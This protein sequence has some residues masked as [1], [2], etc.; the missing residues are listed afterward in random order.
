MAILASSDD[1]LVSLNQ[2]L[3]PVVDGAYGVSLTSSAIPEALRQN[4]IETTLTTTAPSPLA[5]ALKLSSHPEGGW[6]RE[7]WRTTQ[8]F[9]PDGYSGNRTAATAIYIVLGYEE[10][11]QWHKIRSDELRLWHQ[12]SPL[13]LTLGGHGECPSTATSVIRLGPY[14]NEEE[15]LQG[16]VPGGVW[17]R[18]IPL[19]GDVLVSYIVAPGFDY[20]DCSMACK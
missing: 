10:V 8:V 3:D 5:V 20:Q 19:C 9:H 4:I 1:M 15:Q 14:V 12:A 13:E 6:Y 16:L 7:T 11:S 17:H 2:N 18:A